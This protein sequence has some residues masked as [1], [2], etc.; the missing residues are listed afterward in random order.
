MFEQKTSKHIS[1][2]GCA[3]QDNKRPKPSF[4]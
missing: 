1:V 2:Q 3:F 4:P